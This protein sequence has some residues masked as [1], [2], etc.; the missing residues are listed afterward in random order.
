MSQDNSASKKLSEAM[1]DLKKFR[2]DQ[3]LSQQKFGNIV[4]MKYQQIQYYE[5]T[6]Y[7]T[8]RVETFNEIIEKLKSHF[9]VSD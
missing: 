3:G 2:L 4:G 6:G 8:M 7:E 9:G 5:K 1:K